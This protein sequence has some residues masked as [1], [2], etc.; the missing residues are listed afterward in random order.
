MILRVVRHWFVLT[1]CRD[2]LKVIVT[3]DCDNTTLKEIKEILTKL[4]SLRVT[5]LMLKETGI[6]KIV[7]RLGRFTDPVIA[8]L[9]NNVKDTWVESVR[10]QERGEEDI[11][12]PAKVV[13]A[14]EPI[15]T[16]SA[17]STDPPVTKKRKA[18][19]GN[20][21]TNKAM[22][23][24][25]GRKVRIMLGGQYFRYEEASE[26]EAKKPRKTPATKSKRVINQAPVCTDIPLTPEESLRSLKRKEF[27]EKQNSYPDFP[28]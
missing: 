21:V 1:Q 19:A 9:A 24:P 18:V 25:D 2:R 7:G 5:K 27:I 4:V 3:D 10:R 20:T 8:V 23:L 16:P 14:P 28:R 26:H 13:I 17:P 6:G 22:M 15:V 12:E 11:S